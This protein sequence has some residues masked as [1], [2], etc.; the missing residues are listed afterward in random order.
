MPRQET[1]ERRN[2][3]AV[4]RTLQDS[5]GPTQIE[6]NAVAIGLSRPV[7]RRFPWCD[8]EVVEVRKRRVEPV[9]LTPEKIP[10]AIQLEQAGIHDSRG[11]DG[12]R[13]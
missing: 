5:A 6:I 8:G 12:E 3:A 10:G 2:A 1:S 9:A 11:A 4:T 13:P 7:N